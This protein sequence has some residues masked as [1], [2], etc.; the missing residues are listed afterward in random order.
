[1]YEN[2]TLTLNISLAPYDT[3]V[4]VTLEGKAPTKVYCN[5]CGLINSDCIYV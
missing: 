2:E 4:D 1:M 3:G 5:V